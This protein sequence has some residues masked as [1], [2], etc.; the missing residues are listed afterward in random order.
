MQFEVARLLRSRAFQHL[1]SARQEP[2]CPRIYDDRSPT[3]IRD[4]YNVTVVAACSIVATELLLAQDE[5]ALQWGR[6]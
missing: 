1:S 3:E 5:A 6:R 4:H 2:R